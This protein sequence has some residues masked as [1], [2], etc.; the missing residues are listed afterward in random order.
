MSDNFLQHFIDSPSPVMYE[1]KAQQ[2]WIDYIKPLVDEVHQDNYGNVWGVIKSKQNSDKTPFKVLIDAHVDEISFIVNDI[3]ENG[4]V[5]PFRNGGVDMSLSASRDVLILTENGEIDG[6]FGSLPIHQK[7]G[8][9]SDFK[10]DNDNVFIDLGCTSK[11]EVLDLGVKLGDPII[12]KVKS[13]FLKEN[14]L[15]SKSLDDKIGGYINAKVVEK[16][17][18]NQIDLPFDLYI[19][20]S[21]M[22]EVGLFGINMLANEIK[23]DVAIIF[24][25]HFDTTNPMNPN[26]K[27]LGSNAKLGDGVIIFDGSAVQKNLKKLLSDTANEF[28]IKHTFAH[29]TGCGGTNAD[30]MFKTGATTALL[31]IALKYMHTTNEMIDLNDANSAI[32][33]IYR[34][35]QNIKYQH[36]FKYLDL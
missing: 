30:F 5:Y 10:L 2:V 28:E 3:S 35:L 20:S 1:S 17:H 9:M 4:L 34:A 15:V 23:P 26:V 27:S 25:V 29:S 13:R 14:I 33:L 12:Y 6:V 32:D 11:Q 31:S 8:K 18:D 21:V 16:L 22:E 24:D 19:T 7:H 36:N